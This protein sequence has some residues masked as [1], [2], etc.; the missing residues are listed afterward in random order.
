[1]RRKRFRRV[2]LVDGHVVN[3]LRAALLK[4]FAK[5]RPGDV[6]A[7]EEVFSPVHFAARDQ[8]ISEPSATNDR[9]ELDLD[10]ELFAHGAAVAS[11]MR[12]LSPCRSARVQARH[13]FRLV[14]YGAVAL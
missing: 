3:L 13:S 7:E 9:A 1:M 14:C 10:S 6:R 12:R 8:R 2:G 11:P 5:D 4:T